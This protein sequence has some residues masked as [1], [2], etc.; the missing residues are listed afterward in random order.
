MQCIS[1]LNEKQI[2][3]YQKLYSDTEK[4]LAKSILLHEVQKGTEKTRRKNRAHR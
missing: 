4:T 1:V 3:L 2:I